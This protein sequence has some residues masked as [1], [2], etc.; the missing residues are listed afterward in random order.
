M[1][2]Y[3]LRCATESDVPSLNN[4]IRLSARGS[5]PQYTAA[6]VDSLIKYVYGVDL[7][8]VEDSSY[9]VIEHS[10]DDDATRTPVACG[11]W[12]RRRTLFGGS[13]AGEE[14]RQVGFADPAKGEPAKV[15]AF[16][17]HPDHGRKGLGKMML[18]ECER[19]ARDAGFA[20]IHLMATLPGRPFYL[21]NGYEGSEEI[22]HI[23]PD[24]TSVNFE[25]MKKRLAR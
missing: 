4:L 22:S 9:F 3:Q 10:S 15:R 5:S 11:G 20:E 21:A 1:T 19:A 8:L 17:V 24:G 14:L 23:M 18:E 6:E 25:P 2:A 16:F 12:S 13:N 7:E